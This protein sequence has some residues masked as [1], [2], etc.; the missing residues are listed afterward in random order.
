MKR[1]MQFTTRHARHSTNDG[2]QCAVARESIAPVHSTAARGFA[3]DATLIMADAKQAAIVLTAP[4]IASASH[5]PSCRNTDE[6][7]DPEDEAIN[8]ERPSRELLQDSHQPPDGKKRGNR[9]HN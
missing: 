5:E 2:Y 3:V 1:G 7:N 4:N 6:Y 9:G 8:H